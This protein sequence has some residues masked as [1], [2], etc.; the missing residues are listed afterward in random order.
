MSG[1]IQSFLLDRSSI[2]EMIIFRKN[3]WKS[4]SRQMAFCT[5]VLDLLTQ[6]RRWCLARATMHLVGS[7]FRT[8]EHS[9]LSC[10]WLRIFQSSR[11]VIPPDWLPHEIFSISSAYY[12]SICLTVSR[13]SRDKSKFVNISITVSYGSNTKDVK[14]NLISSSSLFLLSLLIW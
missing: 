1:N 12:A 5:R 4:A 11:S 14:L 6:K 3:L 8:V 9:F 7:M 2:E 13:A 10:R